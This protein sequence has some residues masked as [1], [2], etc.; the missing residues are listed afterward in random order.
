MTYVPR[1]ECLLNLGHISA[2]NIDNTILLYNYL[3]D[4]HVFVSFNRNL[5]H[6]EIENLPKDVFNNA[7]DSTILLL[8]LL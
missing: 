2:Y 1:L 4:L 3:L 8:L 5:D 6:N 7:G